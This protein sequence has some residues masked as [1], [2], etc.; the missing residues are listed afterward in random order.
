MSDT[1]QIQREK[2]VL[3]SIVYFSVLYSPLE[4]GVSRILGKREW[5]RER[6]QP[7][8]KSEEGYHFDILDRFYSMMLIVGPFCT[9]PLKQSK[10]SNRALNTLIEQSKCFAN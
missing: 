5:K 8:G 3:F 4:S 1:I 6:E 9:V 7:T 2:C 10:F